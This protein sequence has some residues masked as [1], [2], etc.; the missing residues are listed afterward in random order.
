MSRELRVVSVVEGTSV[1]GPIK[2]LL[3]FAVRVRSPQSG[4]TRVV[5]SLLTTVRSAAVSY[6]NAFI[7]AAEAAAVPLELIQERHAFDFSTVTALAEVL[8]R[9]QP[10]IVES[11]G[12]KPH[13]M[14]LLA[15]RRI[16]VGSKRF[17]WMAFHHGYTT[18]SIKVRLYNQLDRVTL[19]RADRVVTVCNGFARLL[20]S[21]GVPEERIAVLRNA[22]SPS[23][24][25]SAEI[26][27]AL[28]ETL[29]ISESEFVVLAVGRLSSEKG[30]AELIAGFALMLERTHRQDIRLVIVGDGVEAARLQ[31]RARPLGDKVLFAGYQADAWPWFLMSDLFALPSRSEGSPMVLLEAMQARLPIL[32]T[33][34]GGVSETVQDDVSASL[35]AARNS[36]A[37]AAG[38]CRLVDDSELRARLAEAAFAERQRYSTADYCAALLSIYEDVALQA[39]V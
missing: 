8:Q 1:T 7:D 33:S 29:G 9:E 4:Q 22:L 35:V 11:H 2:P 31:A 15:R 20:H 6:R 10:D 17:A 14:V 36:H 24:P 32:A 37:L 18:E 27:R 13:A 23:P 21:R 3:D 25:V 38:L 28:R 39:C 5:Q 16:P 19:P 34:V 12:F 30:H 26:T